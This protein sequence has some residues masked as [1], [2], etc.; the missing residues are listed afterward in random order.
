MVIQLLQRS[1]AAICLRRSPP[2]FCNCA[3][4]AQNSLCKTLTPKILHT[5]RLQAWIT[6]SRTDFR[7]AQRS[8]AKVQETI[9]FFNVLAAKPIVLDPKC[10]QHYSNNYSQ[11]AATITTAITTTSTTVY[12]STTARITTSSN[13]NSSNNKNNYY[14]CYSCCSHRHESFL[15]VY[16]A[17]VC[18]PLYCSPTK[19]QEV[20]YKT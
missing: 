18:K 6:R 13:K 12:Y 10:L 20:K 3:P 11:Q 4:E 5:N 1:L 9:V 14:N 16:K 2:I 19:S 15:Q 8:Q 17:L 7:L